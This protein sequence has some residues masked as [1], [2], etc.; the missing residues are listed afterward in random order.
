MGTGCC[1]LGPNNWV[2]FLASNKPAAGSCAQLDNALCAEFHSLSRNL[3]KKQYKHYCSAGGFLKEE[4]ASGWVL[5]TQLAVWSWGAEVES[6]CFPG[7]TG[8]ISLVAFCPSN[9]CVQC[10]TLT[11]EGRVSC[12]KA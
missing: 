11:L 8:R 12:H 10:L 4:A 9:G 2:P 5:C 6:T 1:R 7:M 3:S